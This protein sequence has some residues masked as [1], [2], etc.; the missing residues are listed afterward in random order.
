MS[1]APRTTLRPSATRTR[2]SLP[3]VVVLPVPFTPTTITMPGLLAA[4]SVLTSRSMSGPTRV[5]SSSR[6]RVRS[7]SGVRVPRTLTRS[8]SRSTSSWVGCTPTSAVSS[9]SSISSQVSSSRCSRDSRVSRPL[10]R[11][12]CERE[13]RARSRT[14][15]PAVGSGT[16]I[17]GISSSSTTGGSS[18]VAVPPSG[19]STSSIVRRVSS[20]GVSASSPTC[21]SAGGA[22]MSGVAGGGSG[23]CFLRRLPTTSPPSAPITTTAMTTARMTISITGPVC[24][25][26]G[27]APRYQ[28]LVVSTGQRPLEGTSRSKVRWRRP[29][30][31]A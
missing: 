30:Q 9:V 13:R 20:R 29:R 23:S 31:R 27:A 14:S 10:P 3:V 19:R 16:S 6:S 12:F 28:P 7:S 24:A 1:A 8:R 15:R 25:T 2:A 18:T 11:A 4:G 17:S 5:I 22:V 21:G 26:P